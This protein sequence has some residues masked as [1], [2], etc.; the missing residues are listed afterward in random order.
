PKTGFGALLNAIVKE[1]PWLPPAI[2]R[3]LVRA[4]GTRVRDILGD[5]AALSDLGR[6]FGSGLTEA[7][8]R[9]LMAEEFAEEAADVVWRRSK[10]GL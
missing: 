4:Y 1:K 6:D 8:V 7:E 9:Y 10:L 2:A 5:A 3:R